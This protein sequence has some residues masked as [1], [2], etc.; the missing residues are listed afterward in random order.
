[1]PTVA[2]KIVELNR[3][4]L[5]P[6]RVLTEDERKCREI[7]EFQSYWTMAAQDTVPHNRALSLRE[8]VERKVELLRLRKKF[9]KHPDR[10]KVDPNCPANLEASEQEVIDLQKLLKKT[11]ND[12]RWDRAPVVGDDKEPTLL[13]D[14]VQLLG[15]A[16][17]AIVLFALFLLTSIAGAQQTNLFTNQAQ[18]VRI[19]P[20]M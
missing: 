3:A 6:N 9:A 8:Q 19:I 14:F 11:S 1:M 17:A 16:K 7:S 18:T 12:R 4:R 15:Q 5:N 2:E 13:E 10:D 20:P